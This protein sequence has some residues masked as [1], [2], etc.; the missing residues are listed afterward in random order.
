MD[1]WKYEQTDFATEWEVKVLGLHRKG[2]KTEHTRDMWA[3]SVQGRVFTGFGTKRDARAYGKR[4]ETDGD[5]HLAPAITD[6]AYLPE[7]LAR[8]YRN[9]AREAG[10]VYDP[11]RL[12]WVKALGDALTS[13]QYDDATYPEAGEVARDGF[14]PEVATLLEMLEEHMEAILASVRHSEECPANKNAM[15]W[16]PQGISAPHL[17]ASSATLPDTAKIEPFMHY[18]HEVRLG[19]IE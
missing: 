8:V 1:V 17:M 2:A 3:V 12:A 11:K 14:E 7:A 4:I 16:S 9:S 15:P 13:G 5:E 6:I 19:G 10:Y 18:P